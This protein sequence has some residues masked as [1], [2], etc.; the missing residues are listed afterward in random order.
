MGKLIGVISK[1]VLSNLSECFTFR[2]KLTKC[3]I[4]NIL[5]QY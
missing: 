1:I 2:A 3:F 4:I 5:N